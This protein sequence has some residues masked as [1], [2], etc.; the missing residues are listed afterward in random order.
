MMER[1]FNHFEIK[2]KIG[3]QLKKDGYTVKEKY[4]KEPKLPIHLYCTKNE[5]KLGEELFLFQIVTAGD[6][7][8]GLTKRL[9]C[10]QR[11]IHPALKVILVISPEIMVEEN[12]KSRLENEG[13]GLWKIKKDCTID[14]TLIE[15][16]SIRQCVQN[17]FKKD[18]FYPEV[19]KPPKTINIAM[20]KY[21]L[22]EED[23]DEISEGAARSADFFIQESIR[24]VLVDPPTNIGESN[25][26]IQ[27]MR[28]ISDLKNIKYS[29]KI[30]E[31]TEEYFSL[32]PEDYD[33][34]LKWTKKLWADCLDM[35]YPDIHKDMDPVLQE[36]YPEYRDHFLHQ[37]QVFLLGLIIIDRLIEKDELKKEISGN[38]QM[39]WLLAS[40]FHDF[41]Y[42]LQLCNK[43]SSV[44]F[45]EFLKI[46]K[47]KKIALLELDRIYLDESFSSN[48]EFLITKLDESFENDNQKHTDLLNKLRLFFY[49]MITQK[50]DHGLLSSMSLLKIAKEKGIKIT[51][52]KFSQIILPAAFA[53]A[54]HNDEIW[55]ILRGKYEKGK[56]EKEIEE[57]GIGWV[58]EAAD[59]KYFPSLSFNKYPVAFLLIFCDSVQEW[60]RSQKSKEVRAAQEEANIQIKNVAIES[61][62]VTVNLLAS[63]TRKSSKF[64]TNKLTEFEDLEIFLKSPYLPFDIRFFDRDDDKEMEEFHIEIR[65]G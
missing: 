57:K 21:S 56:Y 55:K 18:F 38:V 11:L 27:C 37:F 14:T 19:G 52:Q 65:G 34:A 29:D 62:R 54:I 33:F 63:R 40:T 23:V 13:I 41:A 16:K 2:A 53:T 31:L 3:E 25:L 35:P 46:D 49:G 32:N 8:E 58:T 30:K 4:K 5:G 17:K 6:I 44:L 15:P 42:S 59:L 39:S 10:Y 28:L 64:L 51:D 1:K 26:D 60:G 12:V 9:Q 22:N 50:K 43:W 20:K 47:S 48:I 45:G 61:K 7:S 24:L 36:L